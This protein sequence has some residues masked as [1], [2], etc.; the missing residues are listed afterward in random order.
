MELNNG[1]TLTLY[2]LGRVGISLRTGLWAM[3]SRQR[4]GIVVAGATVRYRRRITAFQR[5]EMRTRCLGWDDRFLY[6]E[7]SMWRGGEC[8][9]AVLIRGAVTSKKGI[10]PPSEALAAMGEAPQ[11]PPLPDWVWGWI[12]ADATRSW[13]PET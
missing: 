11:S 7:Q 4:W 2:D 10:V 3:L 5:F 9:S 1:R 8:S 12:D 6:M 13:P